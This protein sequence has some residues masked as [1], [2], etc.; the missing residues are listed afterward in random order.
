VALWEALTYL[1]TRLMD[2]VWFERG[3]REIHMRKA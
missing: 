2:E 1:I 3:G